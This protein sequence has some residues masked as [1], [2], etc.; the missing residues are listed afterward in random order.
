MSR[1]YR[2]ISLLP[3][4]SQQLSL[5][6]PTSRA[7]SGIIPKVAGINKSKQ[8]V[9][10]YDKYVA[11]NYTPLKDVV[12]A[13]GEGVYVYDIEGRRYY[14]FLTGYSAMNQGHRHPKILA[15]LK[16]QA[17]RL[18]LT[19][20]CYYND[21]LGKYAKYATE[22]LGYDRLLPMNGGV[23]ASESSIKMS[24]RWGYEVKGVP[25][26]EAKVILCRGNF[27]GR[28]IAAASSST[29][30]SCF[31]GYGPFVPGFELIPFN[32]I[33]ALEHALKDQHVVAFMVEPIQGEAGIIV[34]DKGY[35]SKARELCTKNNV[36]L[37]CDEIQCGL[38][39]SGKMLASEYESVRP[40]ILVLGKALSGGFMPISAVLA[41]DQYMSMMKSGTHGSTFGGNPLASALAIASLRAIVEGG[42]CE[43][44]YK[45]GEIFRKE[46]A[47][48]RRD[49]IRD[50]RGMGL[51]NAIELNPN[52]GVSASTVNE[53]LRDHGILSKSTHEYTFR[54]APALTINEEQLMDALSLMKKALEE[55]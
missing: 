13:R 53:K 7:F 1:L 32:D 22:L 47:T 11:Q 17:D 10:D 41:D 2:F 29:D 39:R 25:D 37:I 31:M 50:V 9:E 55:C 6:L 24:R 14:D 33:P 26:N 21:M 40:D 23:E 8:V 49:I 16:E 19:G 35:L 12:I 5:R 42:M 52:C 28:S 38:G 44:A 46:A 43:N 45:M 51:F 27:W 20:R 15:A 4:P 3:R 18:T 34:P 30:P 54:M 48:F 36:L